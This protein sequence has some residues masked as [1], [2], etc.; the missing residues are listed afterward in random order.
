MAGALDVRV[1]P[2]TATASEGRAVNVWPRAVKIED[3]EIG[4]RGRR[5]GIVDVPATKPWEP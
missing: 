5:R 3:C 4:V 1:F 2:A